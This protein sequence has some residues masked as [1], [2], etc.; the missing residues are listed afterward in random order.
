MGL[1][2]FIRQRREEL[3]HSIRWVAEKAGVN[4]AYLSQVE[5]GHF[6]PSATW[7]RKL[8]PALK[9]GVEELMRA[10]GYLLEEPPTFAL[11]VDKRYIDVTDI[12]EDTLRALEKIIEDVKRE[13]RERREEHGSPQEQT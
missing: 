7:L 3:G 2:N 9:V 1:G 13:R 6:L 5:R 10:A 8:A 12:P 11:S 4:N